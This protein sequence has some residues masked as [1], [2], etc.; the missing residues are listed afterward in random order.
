[1][2]RN[3]VYDTNSRVLWY[4]IFEMIQKIEGAYNTFLRI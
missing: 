2:C 4:E 3:F 1:M